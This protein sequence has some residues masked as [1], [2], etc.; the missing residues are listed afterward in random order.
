MEFLRNKKIPDVDTCIFKNSKAILLYDKIKIL[1]VQ[2]K[3][4][5][6]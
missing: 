5:I 3:K 4:A 6:E 1:Y 2:S